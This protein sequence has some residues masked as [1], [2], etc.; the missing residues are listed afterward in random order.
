MQGFG[1]RILGGLAG[2]TLGAFAAGGRAQAQ[3][4]QAQANTAAPPAA[5]Q[6]A[7]P[8]IRLGALFPL[9]GPTAVFGDEC[10]RGLELA[11]EDRNAAGGV[12]GRGIA[13]VRADAPDDAAATSE[14]RRLVQGPDRVAAIFGSFSTAIALP[15]SQVAELANMPFF[16]LCALGD[17]VVERGFRWVFRTAPPAAGFAA[18]ALQGVGLVAAALGRPDSSLRL[19]IAQEDALGAQSIGAAQETLIQ[20][21][22]LTLTQRAVYAPRPSDLASLVQRLRGLDAEVVLHVGAPGDEVLL[23]RAMRDANW[24]PRMVIGTAGGYGLA[25]SARSLGA[26]FAGTMSA[27]FTP[28]A[29]NERVAPGARAFAELYLRRYGAEPRSGHGLAC[30]TGARI[31]LDAL[32][33]A[34]STERDRIRAAL[35]ATDLAEGS[36]ACGWGARFDE[37]GQNLRARPVLCQW[38]PSLTN[39]AGQAGLR[40]VAIAPA[41]AAIAAALT[42]LGP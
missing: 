26:D 27:D 11:V 8:A 14:A 18:V 35:M 6:A 17:A 19:V 22:G 16:E 33:R 38:Q 12:F 9:S 1:R 24:R 7:P 29:I 21:R 13:L 41:E 37:R 28:F 31:F 2:A 23:F 32:H 42:R 5:T 10:F 3:A 15:A 4:N 39:P 25:E 36:T 40:Q 34:G 20:E 30:F